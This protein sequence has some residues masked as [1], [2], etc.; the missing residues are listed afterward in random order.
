MTAHLYRVHGGWIAF[1]AVAA[2]CIAPSVRRQ[3]TGELAARASSPSDSLLPSSGMDF[4]GIDQFWPIVDILARNE[5]P[6][7]TQWRAL[8]STPGYRL[9]RVNLGPELQDDIDMAFRPSRQSELVRTTAGDDDHAL[10]L[11]HLRLAGV[12][13]AELI[14]YRDSLAH[15]TPVAD[16]LALAARFL[17][18]GAT[19]R[20]APPLVAFALFRDDGYSLP[21][22]IVVDLLYARVLSVGGT[23]VVKNLAHEFHH[24][25]VNR[26]AKPLPPADTATADSGLRRALIDLRS[27]GLADL[28]DKPYPFRS[29]SPGLQA[30]AA[31]YNVEYARTPAS[32]LQLDTLLVTV[33]G[34]STQAAAAGERAMM[35][36]W[37]NGHP[38][39]AYVAREILETFGVDS[40]YPA[41]FSPVAFLR[42]YAHAERRI[43][44]PNPFS[45]AAWRELDALD[46]RYWRQ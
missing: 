15:A 14:A 30:Y 44:R 23:P 12:H 25:Y 42:T 2:L 13:R 31:R 11:K 38:N 1:A 34:D 26:L 35:L 40:L 33:A 20:G 16:A 24:S 3:F 41:A 43:G 17:P 37:S 36:F 39:G 22:G 45:P 18:P 7:T 8:F 4:S 29:P 27:E 28:I 32:L 46:A 6:S 21:Q 19:S 5:E 9:A 10:A